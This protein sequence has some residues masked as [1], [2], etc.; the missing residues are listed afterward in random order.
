MHGRSWI[1]G[2]FALCAQCKCLPVLDW[3]L[4]PTTPAACGESSHSR[5]WSMAVVSTACALPLFAHNSAASATT[6]NLL[7]LTA[8][9]IGP[10]I[11]AHTHDFVRA[12]CKYAGMVA[13][14]REFQM[15]SQSYYRLQNR[16]A[17]RV[18]SVRQ[19]LEACQVSRRGKK[20]K[21][22]LAGC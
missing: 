11:R 15:C 20:K 13:C 3:S 12:L 7:H 4:V 5:N 8:I 9:V 21:R 16:K 2:G 19:A 14:A 10:V 22:N 17:N 1:H 18:I 6:R